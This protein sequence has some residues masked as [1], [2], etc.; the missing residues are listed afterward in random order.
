M[1]PINFSLYE[2][3]PEPIFLQLQRKEAE[4]KAAAEKFK[5]TEKSKG[6]YTSEYEKKLV[7]DI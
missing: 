7:T 4:D 6:C 2:E 1:S 3:L 5:C